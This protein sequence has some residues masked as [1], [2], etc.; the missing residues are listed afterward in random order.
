MAQILG[1]RRVKI[2]LLV[3]QPRFLLQQQQSF[4]P[5]TRWDIHLS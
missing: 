1:A 2:S 4:R 3:E 5:Q